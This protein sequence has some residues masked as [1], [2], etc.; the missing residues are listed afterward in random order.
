MSTR[1]LSFKRS[2]FPLLL[3]AACLLLAS[4]ARKT[5]AKKKIDSKDEPKPRVVEPAKP[6]PASPSSNS[7]TPDVTSRTERATRAWF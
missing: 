1:L 5:E 7:P 4:C 2:L 6:A 3:A